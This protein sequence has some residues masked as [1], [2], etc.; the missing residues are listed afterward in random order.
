MPWGNGF[1]YVGQFL[2]IFTCLII[3]QKKAWE[4]KKIQIRT[5]GVAPG[6]CFGNAVK[7]NPPLLPPPTPGQGRRRRCGRGIGWT[8]TAA[9]PPP[10][11]HRASGLR[12]E[13]RGEEGPG[14]H[15]GSRRAP[16]PTT[17]PEVSSTTPGGG[18][19]AG[20]KAAGGPSSPPPRGRRNAR[21]ATRK[22]AGWTEWAEMGVITHLETAGK[23]TEE[24]RGYP[25]YQ[26]ADR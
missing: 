13:R 17:P 26:S 15:G 5:Q 11:A 24:K 2:V 20:H 14:D 7:I 19:R 4:P 9:P 12:G 10:S 23:S 21:P 16:P 3:F 22:Y 25:G 8:G 1:K 6:F 18:R